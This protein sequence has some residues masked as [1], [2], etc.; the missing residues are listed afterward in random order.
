MAIVL[1]DEI[2]PKNAG[3]F[4]MVQDVY[5]KGGYRVVANTT[6]RDAITTQRRSEGM[7]VYVISNTTLYYLN[8][9]LTNW[10]AAPFIT[11]VAWGAITGTLSNQ[12]D[13]QSA[14][15]AKQPLDATLTALAGLNT[16]AGVVVQTGT[17]SFTKR[18][19]T[20]TANQ[21]IVADGDGVSGAPTL[22]LPQSI[23]TA[24]TPTFAGLTLTALT[25]LL[26]GNG[27]SAITAITNSSTVGQ[28]LRVTGASTYA[29]GALNLADSDA[30]T[31]D[32]PFANLTQ[33]SARS[34][35]GV[36]G[37]ATADVA[38]IQGTANQVLVVNSAGTALAFGQ[39]NLASTSAVVGALPVG[40]GGTGAI[41]LTS[42][43]LLDR[44]SVV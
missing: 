4:P 3:D 33:G 38:S 14:L 22:S 9:D 41:S 10:T 25:G 21:V 44:K 13:L 11:G 24:A 40:N 32:L 39:V 15:D 30:I 34:V 42:N 29:W 27:A 37:N 20:G 28:V 16:T 2:N 19:I 17:D 8:A 31:G 5:L 43:S 18:T 35:L 12:T 6:A 7:A 1:I 23:H 26:Q 36:T